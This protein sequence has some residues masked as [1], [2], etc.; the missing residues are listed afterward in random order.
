MT[1][2]KL[3]QWLIETINT[4]AVIHPHAGICFNAET[5]VR[6]DS[7]K[8]AIRQFMHDNWEDWDYYTG[9]KTYP[10]PDPDYLGD[11]D[12]ARYMYNASTGGQFSWLPYGDLRIDL[13]KHLLSKLP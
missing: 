13:C 11:I 6:H 4:R 12:R 7:Q 9:S 1:K 2:M 8:F 10:I 3:K 5:L